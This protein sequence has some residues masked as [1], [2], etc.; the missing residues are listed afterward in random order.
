MRAADEDTLFD[1]IAHLPQEAQEALLKLAVGERPEAPKAAPVEALFASGEPD[2]LCSVG[3][4]DPFA[5]PDALRRFRALKDVEALR[6]ALDEP[7]EKWAVFLH[8]SQSALVVRDFSGP[9]RVSGS[10]GT[11]KTVVALHR[12]VY[13]ARKNPN[14]KVLLTTFSD[15]LAHML[16]R[17]LRTLV[18][19]EPDVAARIEV[20][21]IGRVGLDLYAEAFGAA[22]VL[23]DETIRALIVEAR[24]KRP[25]A[26]FSLPFLLGEWF[27]VIEPWLVKSAET[28]TKVSRL[29]RKARLGANQREALWPL[30][31]DVRDAIAAQA[32]QRRRRCSPASTNG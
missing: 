19:G 26:K 28:Y 10:A 29:G 1:V 23:S 7:W 20:K 8:P 9:A 3:P 15:A 2:V 11:G 17:K 13:L 25:G 6:R 18:V 24:E 22:R 32:R 4:V 31:Q 5:H 21:A 16:E 30:F 12:A 14:S 27:D